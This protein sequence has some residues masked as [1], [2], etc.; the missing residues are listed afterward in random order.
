MMMSRVERLSENILTQERMRWSALDEHAAMPIETIFDLFQAGGKRVRPM[1]CIS[2]YLAA[3]GDPDRSPIISAAAALEFLHTCALIHDDIMDGSSLRRGAATVHQKYAAEHQANRWQGEARRFGESV[4]ILAGDLA[5]IYA[6]N[7]MSAAM[8]AVSEAWSELRAE[9]V[10]GEHLDLLAAAR[11]AADSEL[12]RLIAQI[13]SGNYSICRPLVIG[14]LLAG[15]PDLI[16]AFRSF[17]VAVGEAYQLR[18]DLLDVLGNAEITGKPAHL[19]FEGHKMTLLLSLAMER[20]SA[21]RE[22]L[23]DPGATPDLLYR[24]LCD[25]GICAEVESHIHGL[26]AEAQEALD[27]VELEPGWRDELISI[28][29]AAAVRDK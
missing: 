16:E 27:G 17:G 10:V 18:D 23:T 6:D 24:T 3:K 4:A 19:D 14:V 2:G 11:F 25:T 22:L 28:A 21:V 7:L 26:V 20:S 5:L 9:L 8:P 1:L 13:K 15:R 29:R 12:S